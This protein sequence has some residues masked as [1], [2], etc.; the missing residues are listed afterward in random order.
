MLR[1]DIL[2]KYNIYKSKYLRHKKI[3]SH[4]KFISSNFDVN[5]LARE[6]FY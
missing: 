6:S 1:S 5:W 4:K 2:R 3:L